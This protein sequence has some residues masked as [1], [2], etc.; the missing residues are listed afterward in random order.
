VDPDQLLTDIRA[1]MDRI[2]QRKTKDPATLVD[3]IDNLD[4]W[5]CRGGF[6]PF[7]WNR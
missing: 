2:R 1:E 5:L 3:L 7:E 4:E 6:L